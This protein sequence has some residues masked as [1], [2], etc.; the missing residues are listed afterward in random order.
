MLLDLT[1]AFG[2]NYPSFTAVLVDTKGTIGERG[3]L[4]KMRHPHL[5]ADVTMLGSVR[6]SANYGV[7]TIDGTESSSIGFP[8]Q[9]P[10]GAV[11]RS[12]AST[13]HQT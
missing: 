11:A 7:P 12:P 9:R 5:A 3:N 2:S 6:I 1:T 8:L 4:S 13:K 10:R